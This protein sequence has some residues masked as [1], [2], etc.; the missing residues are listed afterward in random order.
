[1]EWAAVSL[2]GYRCASKWASHFQS[3]K[4][5]GCFPVYWAPGRGSLSSYDRS[6]ANSL[7]STHLGGRRGGGGGGGGTERIAESDRRTAFH[8]SR[9][10]P[11][12]SRRGREK[13][14]GVLCVEEGGLRLRAQRW[15]ANLWKT[16]TDTRRCSTLCWRWRRTNTVPTATLKVGHHHHHRLDHISLYLVLCL[17]TPADGPAHESFQ[18]ILFILQ[19][20]INAALHVSTPRPITSWCGARDLDTSSQGRRTACSYIMSAYLKTFTVWLE[21]LYTHKNL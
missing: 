5:R 12:K 1:M 6:E 15:R 11:D 4:S 10:P 18:F 3:W 8:F 14:R 9:A 17:I 16:L 20:E 21:F 2:I 19:R 13:H 7:R